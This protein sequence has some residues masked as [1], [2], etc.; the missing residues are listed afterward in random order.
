MPAIA[1]DRTN[2]GPGF[3]IGHSFFTIPAGA[4]PPTEEWYCSIIETEV[5]PLLEEYWFED[6]AKADEWRNRLLA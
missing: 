1:G 6:Q 2:L 3:C 5:A 4:E